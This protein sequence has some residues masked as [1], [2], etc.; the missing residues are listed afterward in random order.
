M[1]YD[2]DI[3]LVQL[4]DGRW[5]TRAEAARA[6]SEAPSKL[7]RDDLIRL[8]DDR[9]E[10]VRYWAV[11]ALEALAP[12]D[13]YGVLR[14]RLD[15]PAAQVRMAA[16]RAL[17]RGRGGVSYR[18]VLGL[19]SDQDED[20][21]H[22]AIQALIQAPDKTIR[23]L[24][25]TL[26]H[27]RW[28]AREA[29][30]EALVA[31]GNEAVPA[32]LRALDDGCEDVQFWAIRILGRLRA[33]E[34]LPR[35]REILVGEVRELAQAAMKSLALLGDR[36]S[37]Q[38]I[39]G[40]LG[41]D[42]D[43]LRRSA[44]EALSLFGDFAV[45]LLADL[46]DSQK[47]IVK[48]AASEAL[49]ASGDGALIPIFEKLRE[50]SVD[51]RYWAVR[52]LER[53]RTA[54]VV[55]LLIDLLSDEVAE[56]QLAAAEALSR[57]ELPVELAD[58]VL[59]HLGSKDW[60]VRR[61]VAAAAAAQGH[62]PL[63]VLT[64]WLDEDEED[65]RYWSVRILAD[66]KDPLSLPLLTR[67]FEDPAWPIRKAAAEAISSFG[68]KAVDFLRQEITSK[69][70]D[71]NQRYWL[72]RALVGIDD[73][74]LV[75][76]LVQLLVDPDQ[77][78]R[79]NAT[80]ALMQLGERVVPDLMHDLRSNE[81]RAIRLG[82]SEVL[83]RTGKSRVSE[84]LEL[85]RFRDPD[86]NYWATTILQGLGD[87]AVGPLV[88]LVR[89]GSEA[90]RFAAFRALSGIPNPRTIQLAFESLEDE[91]PSMRAI[92][93]EVFGRYRVPEAREPLLE[94]LASG[95]ESPRRLVVEALGRIGGEGVSEALL[96]QLP[97]DR[98]E[99][100]KTVYAAL[101]ELA[102]PET[103]GRQLELLKTLDPSLLGF[104]LDSLGAVGEPEDVALVL[105]Q[106]DACPAPSLPRLI[107]CLGR[108]G[109]PKNASV[110]I[111]FLEDPSW[112]IQESALEAYGELGEGADPEPLKEPARSQDPLLRSRARAALKRVL[113][114]Q[115]WT[116]MLRGQLKKTLE[117]PAEELFAKAQGFLQAGQREAARE[118]LE[119]AVRLSKRPHYFAL[120]GSLSMES[121]D[122]ARAEEHLRKAYELSPQ[123]A[124][125]QV[126]LGVVQAMAG[127]S[128]LAGETL[129]AVLAREDL[130]AP[131]R[132]LAQRTLARLRG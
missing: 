39:V 14:A 23:P 78:V 96:E 91:Y 90:E 93:L 88:E 112:E 53:F 67:R 118:A 40:F 15:D 16:V 35:L 85:L 107:H 28:K 71:S 81:D 52:A 49:G 122:L 25:D 113:G 77:G 50:D 19:L 20:V 44:V 74:S 9:V 106:R 117:D 102:D 7:A 104:A 132:D 69:A 24:I 103:R 59:S 3:L 114:P 21:V 17:A 76:S 54:V 101:E 48:F 61:A 89:V 32:L 11:R 51:L 37:L 82:I 64:S 79:Q 80:D 2:L 126:K 33:K 55:P 131:V 123:D 121:K 36:A 92:A 83:I 72:S 1:R 26:A 75:P 128:E 66:R 45:K 125:S 5:A 70:G 65:L 18:E 43:G 41:S 115:A 62:W 100:G 73:S 8:L 109:G 34:A 116:R 46:L 10:K 124:V 57:F 105:E 38:A 86:L 6:F 29:A 31:M 97:A 12:E 27:P 42:D 98:W 47:R 56:I 63:E 111:P 95:E 22:W 129:G 130:A 108:I 13:L 60:R 68:S 4:R 87:V 119:R 94:L 30:A 99:M 120:L 127:K 84:I 110:L 58:R